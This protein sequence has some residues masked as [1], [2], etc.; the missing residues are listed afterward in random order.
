M[1]VTTKGGN[2]QVI[3]ARYPDRRE[4]LLGLAASTAAVPAR[5]GAEY[6]P[7]LRDSGRD[8]RPANHVVNVLDFGAVA[9]GRTLST[10]GIQ[11][12]INA[13]AAA[14]GGKVFVPPGK[15]LTGP[16]FLKSNLEFEVLAGATL[17]GS[18]NFADYPTI[19]GR[20]EGLDRTVY[21]SLITGIDLD[22][23]A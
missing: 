8:S 14:G 21:A 4:F 6:S 19:A 1:A 17:L 5:A 7:S 12:A 11:A 15:Y 23:V 16:I 18:T 20:W 2:T 10:A 3:K 9:D 22:S 13:C